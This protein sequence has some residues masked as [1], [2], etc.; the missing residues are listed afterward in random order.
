MINLDDLASRVLFKRYVVFDTETD[1]IKKDTSIYAD[2][3]E[4]VMGVTYEAD[5]D[6]YH[7]Y[8]FS[9]NI[10]NGIF[11]GTE[12]TPHIVVGHNLTFDLAVLNIE[13]FRHPNCFFWDTAVVHYELS[14]QKET[15]PSLN[16]VSRFYGFGDKEDKVSEMIKAGVQ[17][18]DIEAS[19]LVEYCTQDVKLTKD[20]FLRQLE[21]LLAMSR[22]SVVADRNHAK[23]VLERM[24]Y[25]SH[26]H[27]MSMQGMTVDRKTLSNGAEELDALQKDLAYDIKTFME[28]KLVEMPSDHVNPD[29]NQQLATVLYGGPYNYMVSKETGEYFKTG[30]RAGQAKTKV[31]KLVGFNVDRVLGPMV[32]YDNHDTSEACLK[33]LL[34]EKPT[35]EWIDF[36]QAVLSYRKITKLKSTYYDAY[37]ER[38]TEYPDNPKLGLIQCEFKHVITPTGRISSTKPNIQNIKGD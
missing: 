4:F 37:S 36:I 10:I 35:T 31:E 38:C 32:D 15:F 7:P 16:S 6:I 21:L 25:R 11:S 18:K 22:S 34:K 26:T 33:N 19:L 29:S 28:G 17:P 14:G 1:L 8:W 27:D 12:S 20:I 2:T 30:T 23:L 3:P 9:V 13:T 5:P 24:Q